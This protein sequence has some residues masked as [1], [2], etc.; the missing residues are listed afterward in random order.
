[1]DAVYTRAKDLREKV[2]SILLKKIEWRILFSV[3]GERTV[4]EI[5][6]K[7]ER[8][9]QFVENVLNELMQKDL[10]ELL[11]GG[12]GTDD[13]RKKEKSPKKTDKKP[14][15]KK[16]K[17]DDTAELKKPV[18]EPL[19]EEPSLI[20]A[21]PVSDE[22]VKKAE[23]V[24]EMPAKKP[25]PVVTAPKEEKLEPV[26]TKKVK[27]EESFSLDVSKPVEETPKTVPPVDKTTPAVT[28]S[29]KQSLLVIDD[30]VVIQKMV[31]IA[32]ENE[33]YHIVAAM[34]GED[35]LRLLKE[36]KPGLILL[37][38]MLPDMSG[39]DVMKSIKALGGA[40]Q[41]IPIIML[42]GKDSPQDKDAALSNGANGFLTKPFHDE[43]LISKVKEFMK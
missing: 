36:S 19:I 7:V 32:L 40:Y 41:N 24:K 12:D 3:N 21:E 10:I 37:D 11:S 16:T 4:N 25:E 26:T 34:K 22:P 28:A 6:T 30:S 23:S 8:D 43:D 27:E 33:P 17:S 5:A 39:L 13:S 9:E 35:A 15:V 29:G 31:E 42:S 2:D 14:A 20:K 38:I 18:T 1:V